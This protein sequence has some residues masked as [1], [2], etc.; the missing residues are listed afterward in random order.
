M[1]KLLKVCTKAEMKS[2]SFFNKFH[3]LKALKTL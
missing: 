1:K 3:A 2:F